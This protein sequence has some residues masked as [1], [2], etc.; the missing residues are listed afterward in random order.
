MWSCKLQF[1]WTICEYRGT[2]M[3]LFW[4]VPVKPHLPSVFFVSFPDSVRAPHPN[5]E[6]QTFQQGTTVDTLYPGNMVDEDL[7]TLEKG[8]YAPLA[9]MEFIPESHPASLCKMWA[10]ERRYTRQQELLVS[11]SYAAKP[12]RIERCTSSL[13]DVKPLATWDFGALGKW[14]SYVAETNFN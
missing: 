7:M 14:F 6:P 12:K 1:C 2:T 3:T 9:N 5:P 4:G 10:R 8:E 13:S 11:S